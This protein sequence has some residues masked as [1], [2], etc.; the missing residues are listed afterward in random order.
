MLLYRT[1]SYV[2]VRVSKPLILRKLV[3]TM[4]SAG[5]DF[6]RRAVEH[7]QEY[8][9]IKTVQPNPDYGEGFYISLAFV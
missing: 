1:L 8:L 9:R 2:F 7:F 5:Q 4:S 3:S 6:N